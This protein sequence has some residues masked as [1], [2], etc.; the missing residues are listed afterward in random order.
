[1]VVFRGLGYLK[2]GCGVGGVELDNG[3]LDN[4]RDVVDKG[5]VRVHHTG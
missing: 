4:K 5:L 1:M 2:R 3:R